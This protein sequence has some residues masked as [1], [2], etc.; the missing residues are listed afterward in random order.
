LDAILSVFQKMIPLPPSR[1]D[2]FR[3]EETNFQRFSPFLRLELVDKEKRVFQAERETY[4]GRGGW[5]WMG[6]HG[7]LKE[8]VDNIIPLLDTDKFFEFF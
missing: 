8:L 3:Q 4:S 7:A 5:R 2:A 6:A 1:I